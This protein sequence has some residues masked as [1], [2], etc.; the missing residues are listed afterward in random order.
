MGALIKLIVVILI[1]LIG[2]VV[3]EK[4]HYKSIIAREKE[5]L[6]L[7]AITSKNFNVQDTERA[8]L[9]R[10]NVVV[11]LD[12][13]KRFLAGIRNLIGGRIKSYESLIDRARREAILRMKQ[14]AKGADIIVNMRFQTSVIGEISD[15]R[16]SLGCV[17]I[18]AY[19]TAVKFKS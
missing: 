1:Y 7:P 13:F 14:E 16:D 10:G 2:T 12:Y 17:E 19:G 8:W 4:R 18:L 11:S 15:K 3:I 6:S 5:F 9:V